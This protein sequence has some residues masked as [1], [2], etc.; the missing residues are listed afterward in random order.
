[1]IRLMVS[2]LFVV[3]VA[4]N[5]RA[6]TSQATGIGPSEA[7]ACK[8]AKMGAATLQTQL[9]KKGKYVSVETCQCV[10]DVKG[11]GK[12]GFICTVQVSS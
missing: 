6:D 3:C 8:S 1:M 10:A 2:G 7:I 12:G 4:A 9:T 11:D 5:S